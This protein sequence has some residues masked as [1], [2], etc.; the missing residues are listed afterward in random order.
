VSPTERPVP[1]LFWEQLELRVDLGRFDPCVG[2]VT[3]SPEEPYTRIFSSMLPVGYG[4]FMVFWVRQIGSSE[5]EN[6]WSVSPIVGIRH[7]QVESVV[8]GF[9]PYSTLP[10]PV[11][12]PWRLTASAH[13]ASLGFAP[14]GR[15]D[16]GNL[17]KTVD[18]VVAVFDA[19]DELF[20]KMSDLEWIATSEG[21][22]SSHPETRAVAYWMLGRKADAE[23]FL[24]AGLSASLHPED[25][26]AV[27]DWFD[28]FSTQPPPPQ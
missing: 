24:A 21:H 14:I 26:T 8:D 28:T 6:L 4:T 1:E 17:V 18:M 5:G 3:T 27:I 7:D 11:H 25:W 13:V 9:A 19:L 15:V 20:V 22:L 10:R 16:H 12:D 2:Y 23:A